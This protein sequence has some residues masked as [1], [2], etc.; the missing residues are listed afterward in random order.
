LERHFSGHGTSG[1]F[2]RGDGCLGSILQLMFL[3][4][5]GD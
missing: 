3:V 4:L 1:I 5:R 2:F